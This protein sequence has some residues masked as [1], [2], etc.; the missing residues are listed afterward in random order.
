ME[1][2]QI[3]DKNQAEKDECT[4]TRHKEHAG[5]GIKFGERCWERTRLFSA[6]S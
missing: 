5:T 2:G 1:E 3:M 6:V 4:R